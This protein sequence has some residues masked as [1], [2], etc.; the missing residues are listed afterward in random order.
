[1]ELKDIQTNTRGLL[2][3]EKVHR[4]L[5]FLDRK[6]VF[7]DVILKSFTRD[8]F[9]YLTVKNIHEEINSVIE[10]SFSDEECVVVGHSLGTIISY[11]VLRN[12][13]H[14]KVKKYI[15]IGSPL[16]LTAVR[17]HLGTPLTMPECVMQKEWFNAYDERDFVALLPLDKEN[18][19]IQPPII[20]KKDV[21]NHTDNRH[22]ISG[23][24]DDAVVAKA[25]YD[26]LI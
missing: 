11:V 22:G 2:N 7:G 26:A 10:N 20:N 16:G 5:T 14:L 24:L 19:N 18:F 12:H 1:M 4:L 13:P 21:D 15:T 17:M 8:V 25:I 9:M 6:K 23:Y 3:N